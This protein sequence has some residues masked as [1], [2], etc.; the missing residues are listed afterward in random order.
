MESKLTQLAKQKNDAE[1]RTLSLKSTRWLQQKIATMR[2]P[3]AMAKAI[4]DERNQNGLKGHPTPTATGKF[5][6]GGLYYFYYNPKHKDTLPYYDIFPLVIPLQK[7]SDGFLGLN[8]HYLPFRYRMMFLM[9]LEKFAIRNDQ[10][11]VSRYR[12]TYDILNASRRYREFKPCLKQYLY[13]HIRSRIIPVE[14]NEW[15]VAAALPVQQFKKATPQ[16]VWEE[17]IEQIRNS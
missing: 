12:V 7:T 17:S 16:D 5:L 10:D 3:A 11:E 6:I 15:D 13:G 14:P 9:K 8:L 1:L 4:R 2:N